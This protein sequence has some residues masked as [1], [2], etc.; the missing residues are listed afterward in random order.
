[1]RDRRDAQARGI[2]AGF[3]DK[4]RQDVRSGRAMQPA[5]PKNAGIAAT[6][7]QSCNVFQALLLALNQA[8]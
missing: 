3:A 8:F 4:Y 2:C 7:R 6:S 5:L 1:M